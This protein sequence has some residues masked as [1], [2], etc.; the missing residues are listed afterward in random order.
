[1]L[2]CMPYVLTWQ[3]VLGVYVFTWQL[4]LRA[5]VPTC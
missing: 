4:A 2:N 1:M 5:Y 3:R